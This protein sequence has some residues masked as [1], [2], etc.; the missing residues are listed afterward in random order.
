MPTQR[1]HGGAP[2]VPINLVNPG[3]AGLN[4]E[5]ES[6]L[7]PAEWATT[8]TNVVFD[9]AGRISLRKGWVSQTTN[10]VAGVLMRV[11]EYVKADGTVKTIAS[12]D[13]DIFNFADLDNPASIEGTLGITEGNIKFVNFND[14]CIALG[15]GT[16]ANPSVYTGAGNF[17]TLSVSSGTAPTSGIGTAAYGRLWVVDSDGNTI[18]YCA[19]LDETKWATVDG[20]GTIDMSQVWSDGQDQVKAIAAFAGDLIIFGNNEIVTW[21]DGQGADTGLNP[22]NIY[23]SDTIPSMGCISQ[24][25]VAHALG[26]L[27]F[28]SSSGI[29]TMS[30]MLQAK[31][32]PTFNMSRNVQSKMLNYLAASTDDND[33]TL[34]YSPSE[35]FILAIFPDVDKVICIDTKQQLQDSTFR[36]SEWATDLQ[37]ACYLTNRTLMGSLT[38]TVGELFLHSKF[39]DDGTS[40]DFAYQSGWL[41]LGQDFNQYLKFVKKL[42]SFAFIGSD[43]TLNFNVEYDFGSKSFTVAKSAIG[44][45]GAE[46]N[47]SEFYDVAT[48]GYKDPANTSL[49]ITEFSGGVSLRTM[50]IPGQGS[51]QYIKVGVNL[52]S[53]QDTFALQQINLFAKIGRIAT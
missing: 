15:T 36:V 40:Y 29:Q 4:T 1:A 26:D 24:F 31:T 51:G 5:A 2:L 43:V 39:N 11:H 7:L 32:T 14:K 18:R 49:G 50:A 33:I 45:A 25:A 42:T 8:L 3:A 34:M 47:V 38:G 9:S 22:S 17:T 37:T 28:I 23:I 46:F 10:A 41:D 53:A 48:P 52:D 12:S 30:R 35:E 13:A 21:T 6:S 19:L 20:G 44:S 16:S 27:W